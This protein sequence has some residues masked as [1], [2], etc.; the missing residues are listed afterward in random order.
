MMADDEDIPA[1]FLEEDND[2]PENILSLVM[3][4]WLHGNGECNLCRYADGGYICRQMLYYLLIHI[5][6]Q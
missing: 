1:N 3:Y 5:P 2:L 6:V 4:D